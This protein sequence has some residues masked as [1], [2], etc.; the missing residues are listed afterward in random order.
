MRVRRTPWRQARFTVVDLETTGLDPGRDEIISYAAIPI[1]EG[2]ARPAGLVAGIVRP[3][4]MPPP[5]TIRIHGLRPADLEEAPPLDA[6]LDELL[7]A[8]AERAL[9]AHVARIETEFLGRAL[10]DRDERLPGPVIDTAKLAEA[11]L[12]RDDSGRAFALDDLA[13]RLGL[14]VHRRHHAEGDA[15]TTA[16]VFLALARALEKRRPQT[17]RSLSRAGRG[18]LFG[19]RR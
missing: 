15:L 13:T 3:E 12:G 4:R 16:Q 14:P 19:R 18:W 10:R 6:V 2:R 5:E 11:V 1:D 17:V 9:I 8:M 7:A